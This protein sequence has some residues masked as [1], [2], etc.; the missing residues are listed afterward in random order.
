MIVL[1]VVIALVGVLVAVKYS[2]FLQQKSNK[3]SSKKLFNIV[4][5]GA[6]GSGKGT[7]SELIKAKLNMLQISAG[8]VLRNFIKDNPDAPETKTIH[9]YTS[10]GKLVP[11]EITHKLIRK[12][13]EE[14]VL[15]E[16]CSYS[17]IIFDGFPREMGQLTFLDAMLS[18]SGNKINAVV[19]MD[20]PM[21]VLVD[22]LSGRFMCAKCGAIYHKTGHPTQKEGVCDKCGSTEF[23]VREDDQNKDAIRA[24]FKIF[25]EQ[26]KPVLEVY[27]KRGIVIHA[28]VSK[29]A[30]ETSDELLEKIEKMRVK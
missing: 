12:V 5:V 22:R 8:D 6:A 20:I 7:Q 26:T 3:V 23:K 28:D 9:E 17:G 25:E 16:K 29:G 30:K 14:Q 4:M 15:C 24:R 27:E 1:F 18:E 11:Q 19:S 21:E 10:Q 13:V 2:K